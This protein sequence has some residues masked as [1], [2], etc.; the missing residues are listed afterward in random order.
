M[1]G[2]FSEI[3]ISQLS[4]TGEELCGDSVQTVK[5]STHTIIVVSD[6]LGSGVKA[7]ILS[8]MT[9]RIATSMLKRG[10][11]LADVVDT[12]AQTLPICRQ[13]KI[14]YSTLQ[15]IKIAN[16]GDTSVVEF[17]SPAS[18]LIRK[19]K[20][21]PFPTEEKIVAGKKLRM[22][23][24]QLQ[25]GDILTAVSDGVIHAG[26][27]GLLKLGWGW[28][29]VLQQLA[30]TCR[31]ECSAAEMGKDI[32][33]C[34]EGYYLGRPGDDCTVVMVK[35]RQPVQLMLMA[36]PPMGREEDEL[37]VRRLLAFEGKKVVSGGTTANIVSRVTGKP[38]V[39]DITYPNPDIPPTAC[40]EGIDLVTEGV[41][42]LNA[43]SERLQ[44]RQL[45][46]LHSRLQ[47]GATLLMKL[48][49]EADEINILAGKAINPAHQNPHF[50]VQIN[51]KAQ[52]L[53]KLVGSL[54]E[55]GKTVEIEWV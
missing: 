3:G 22:G 6:G 4:K 13:R 53:D 55:V 49:L 40:I 20:I 42:T 51:L 30:I 48:L 27:G 26:I 2:L 35:L 36:G 9:T 11:S 33:G 50:P 45:H 24:L 54:R 29:G 14:A 31:R 39:V 47:D 7:N 38:A 19:G 46:Y 16:N 23:R 25:E 32:I 52:V 17:D 1:N 28:Q 8:T 37:V 15:I 34:C 41:L 10:T 18:F 21:L 12:I 43:V 44:S 5:T